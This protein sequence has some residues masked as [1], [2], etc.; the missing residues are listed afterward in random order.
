MSIGRP[1]SV[2]VDLKL[3]ARDPTAWLPIALSLAALLDVLVFGVVLGPVAQPD[4]DEG[5]PARLFQGLMLL[6]AV[7][8]VVF[9]VRW[10]PRTPREAAV[11]V[12]L[13][14]VAAAVPLLVLLFLE[15]GVTG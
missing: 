6:T 5:T 1:S 2:S 7:A 12:G 4:G 11:I 15:S 14:V 8:V 3:V 13:Q 9:A 10:L